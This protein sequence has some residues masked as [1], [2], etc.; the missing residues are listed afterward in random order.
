MWAGS[1]VSLPGQP[2]VD[3]AGGEHHQGER[4]GGGVEPEGASHDQG[5]ALVEPFEARVGEAEPDRG[6]DSVTVFADGAA[7]LDERLE[8]AALRPRTPAVDQLGDL[9][10]GEVAGEDRP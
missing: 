4:G 1:C 7:G 10:L 5:D 2:E 6:E 3:G 8:P 9:V